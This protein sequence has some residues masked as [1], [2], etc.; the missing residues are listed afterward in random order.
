VHVEEKETAKREL[1]VGE[2]QVGYFEGGTLRT[3]AGR[4]F[5]LGDW[6]EIHRPGGNVL[7]LKA[8]VVWVRPS[9]WDPRE[10]RP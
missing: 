8:N 7:L 10:A 5:D 2:Q 1:G 9:R 3:I 4:A 6:V